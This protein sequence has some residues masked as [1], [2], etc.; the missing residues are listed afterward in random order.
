M[1]RNNHNLPL[2]GALLGTA[3]LFFATF[4]VNY[5]NLGM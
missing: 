2:Y 4:V 5:L 3:A 1:F